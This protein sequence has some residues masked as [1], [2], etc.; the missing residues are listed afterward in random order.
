MPIAAAAHGMNESAKTSVVLDASALLALMLGE[1][2]ADQVQRYLV[3]AC[4]AQ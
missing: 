3:D 2:G 4:M 1:R